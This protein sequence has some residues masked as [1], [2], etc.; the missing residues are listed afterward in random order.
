MATVGGDVGDEGD[1]E[2]EEVCR[3]RAEGYNSCGLVR[4]EAR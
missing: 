2:R 3:S 4:S 1:E